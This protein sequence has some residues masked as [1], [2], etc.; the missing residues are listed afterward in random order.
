M[1]SDFVVIFHFQQFEGFSGDTSDV[2]IIDSVDVDRRASRR[3]Q[4]TR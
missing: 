3:L 2:S 4:K 1:L